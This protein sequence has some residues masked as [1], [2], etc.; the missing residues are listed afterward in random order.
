MG[1]ISKV[2]VDKILSYLNSFGMSETCKEFNIKESTVERYKLEKRFI[3]TRQPKILLL[4]IE[5]AR[6][7]VGVW[8][9]GKQYVGYHQ[10]IKDWFI[11]GWSCK[12]LFDFKVYSDFVTPK[13]A[14]ERDD[15]RVCHSIWKMIED[16]DIV[17][18]HNGNS[19][20]LPK[21]N[22]R[23]IANKILP[24]SSFNSI[25][26]CR[27][28]KKHFSFSS[29]AL[30]YLGR[31]LLRKEKLNTNY[32]LWIDCEQ[33][34]EKQLK[35]MQVYCD[36]DVSLLE[37]VY[38]ELRPYIKSHP[39]LGVLMGSEEPCCPNCGSFDIDDTDSYYT[40]PQNMYVSV[41]CNGCGAVNRRKNTELTKKQRDVLLVSTAR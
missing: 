27:A 15:D 33:G 24:N 20:D 5:T 8:Q 36:E 22:T 35:Y 30:N 13:E 39:N 38:L 37:E 16:A 9:T 32:Q 4:D 41:R 12:W 7:W 28:S 3:N 18:T 34:N 19:F 2:R 17:I 21:I 26:T 25:D 11:L 40:T 23:Y 29:N 14:I 1:I 10:I 6:M 31:Y